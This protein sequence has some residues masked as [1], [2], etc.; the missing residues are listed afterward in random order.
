MPKYRV[1]QYYN[2]TLYQDITAPDELEAEEIA[3]NRNDWQEPA[4]NDYDDC[5]DYEVL[6]IKIK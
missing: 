5:I 3:I 6:P 2:R 4:L 1:Y